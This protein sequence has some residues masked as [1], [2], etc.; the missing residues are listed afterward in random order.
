MFRK[1][2]CLRLVNF[3]KDFSEDVTVLKPKCSRFAKRESTFEGRQQNHGRKKTLK[4][5]DGKVFSRQSDTKL[6]A[7]DRAYRSKYT[8]RKLLIKYMYMKIFN[9]FKPRLAVCLWSVT[10]IFVKLPLDQ[11]TKKTSQE[12]RNLLRLL[13]MAKS[14]HQIFSAN[15]VSR[16]E[17][18]SEQVRSDHYKVSYATSLLFQIKTS[19]GAIKILGF[20]MRFHSSVSFIRRFV[21]KGIFS[22]NFNFHCLLKLQRTFKNLV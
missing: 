7:S 17:A 4:I 16:S 8:N 3:V 12:L 2:N 6:S 19:C 18:T 10:E 14:V 9:W 20:F 22:R 11:A 5:P 13:G 1:L 21:L 15:H